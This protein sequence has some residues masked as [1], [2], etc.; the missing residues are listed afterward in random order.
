MKYLSLIMIIINIIVIYVT[1][2]YRKEAKSQEEIKSILKKIMTLWKSL[3]TFILFGIAIFL[4]SFTLKS[5][6]NLF[7]NK[8]YNII[9]VIYVVLNLFS[10]II[11]YKKIGI[12]KS[13]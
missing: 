6:E 12:K 7:I 2:N 4:L 11:S 10:L 1:N 9:V 13:K 5:S 3:S 8:G